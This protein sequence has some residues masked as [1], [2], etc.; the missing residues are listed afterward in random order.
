MMKELLAEI[1]T[2]YGF[3]FVAVEVM[4]DQ[5]HLLKHTS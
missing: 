3:E 2:Q 1:A 5:L 4:P